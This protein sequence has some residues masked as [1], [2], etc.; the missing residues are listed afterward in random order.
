MVL[1]N[2]CC[3]LHSLSLTLRHFRPQS[4]PQE[5][6]RTMKHL[7]SAALITI[8]FLTLC[9]GGKTSRDK[10]LRRTFKHV[11]KEIAGYSD[12]VKEIINLAVHGKAQNRS[13]DRLALFVDAIG[14]RVSGSRNLEMAIR[15]MYK[16][17]QK[18]GLENVALEPVKVPHW[19]RGEETAMMLEPRNQSI[20]VLGLGSS[21]GTPP[22]GTIE[23]NHINKV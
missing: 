11:K 4:I 15:Y 3:P 16:E 7:H 20:A 1:G 21:V 23:C 6:P 22:E 18:D 14:N 8:C 19:V 2:V 10:T 13:Y 17:L 12:I 9:V 5:S